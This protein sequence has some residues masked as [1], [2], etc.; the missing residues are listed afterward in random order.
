M[1]PCLTEAGKDCATPGAGFQNVY[2]KGRKE[3]A[4]ESTTSC[5]AASPISLLFLLAPSV[6]PLVLSSLNLFIHLVYSFWGHPR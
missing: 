5:S 3:L 1:K 4:E 2:S 6:F